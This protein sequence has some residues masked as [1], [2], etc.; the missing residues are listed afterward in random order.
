MSNSNG[1]TAVRSRWSHTSPTLWMTCIVYVFADVFYGYDSGM[2]S[3]LQALPSFLDKFGAKIGGKQKLPTKQSSIMN[4]VVWAGKLAGALSVEPMVERLGFKKAMVV[5]CAVQCLAAIIELVSPNWKVFTFGRCLSYVAQGIAENAVPSYTSDIAPAPVRSTFTGSLTFFLVIGQLWSNLMCRAYRLTHESKGWK[6][7]VAMQLVPPIIILIGLPFTPESPRWLTAHGRKEEA[8]V[9]LNRIRPAHD[10]ANGNTE[11]EINAIDEAIQE[12]NVKDRGTWLDIFRG[13][14]LRRSLIAM[15]MFIVQQANG[16]QFIQSFGAT[17]Y[18]SMG[19]GDMSF[20]YTSITSAAIIVALGCALYLYDKIGRRP[21]MIVTSFIQCP[22]ILTVAIVGSAKHQTSANVHGVVAC[23]IL[24]TSF[25]RCATDSPS[26][27][28]NSE[29]GG[30]KLRKKI[31][32]WSTWWQVIAAFTVSYVSPYLLASPGLD[33]GAKVGYIFFVISSL[34]FLFIVFCVPELKGRSLEEID[35]LFE[36]RLWAWQ[37][38]KA[39]TSGVGARIAELEGAYEHHGGEKGREEGI[40][41]GHN[42]ESLDQ[43]VGP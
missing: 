4:S 40:E 11:A 2:F 28:I 37:F 42:E 38:D 3:S 33:L 18:I 27:I 23:N 36:Q 30:V 13:T 25:A 29:I 17:F 5:L 7:P 12:S 39:V 20:T 35:E 31:M 9:A 22:L 26:Y 24:F 19:Y 10:V 21:V 34:G 6:I 43:K 41:M 16:T 32:A 14:Y 8:L 1:Q 15:F